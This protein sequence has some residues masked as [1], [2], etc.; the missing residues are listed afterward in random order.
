LSEVVTISAGA[1]FTCTAKSGGAASC[2]GAN[3][4]GELGAKDNVDHLT[5]TPV[6]ASVFSLPTGGTTFLALTGVVAIVTGTSPLSPTHEHACAL[7]VTGVIRCWGDNS[8]GE[9]G[10]GTTTNRARPT[11]VNSFAA[12]VDPTA[13]LRNDRIA[14]VTVLIN[15]DAGSQA[16]IIL[17]LE[18]GD[19]SGDG[20]AEA[21]CE[22][23]LLRVPMTI[24]ARGPSGFRAG[25]ATAHVEAIVRSD[26]SILEDT[27]WTRQV[28]LAVP[29]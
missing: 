11:V 20:H 4:A 8:Q 12:N 27:H 21:R 25:P 5:P 24:P 26:S 2:W 3:D 1:F 6:A 16:H 14:E 9:I 29:K 18:Q 19:V 10:D 15:C 7:L 23:R 17:S 28:T 13:T 22:G